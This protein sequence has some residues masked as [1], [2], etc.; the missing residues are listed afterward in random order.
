MSAGGEKIGL[1]DGTVFVDSITFG[2][3]SINISYGRYP[4]AGS[5]WYFF[6]TPTPGSA[7]DNQASVM[8]KKTTPVRAKAYEAGLLPS[9]IVTHT[10]I[11]DADFDIATLSVVTDPPNLWD[12]D[13]GIYKNYNERGDEWERPASIE[14]YESDNSLEFSCDV[15]LRIHGGVTRVFPKKSLRYYFRSEYGQSTLN[16]RLFPNKN[17]NKFKRFVSSASFQ[18]SPSHSSYDTGTLMRDPLAHALGRI[19]HK[20]LSLG[21]RPV[22]LFLNG[23]PWGIYNAMEHIAQA[24]TT[25]CGV[26]VYI[27]HQFRNRCY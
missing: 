3:Q 4:D 16:Y 17:L 5:A 1:Y 18:D 13:F 24:S 2:E 10:Y 27:F 23:E 8:I 25:R 12:P 22:A 20:D 14:F 15:G 26:M 6:P 11:F 19:Y 9:E 7:N 21:T